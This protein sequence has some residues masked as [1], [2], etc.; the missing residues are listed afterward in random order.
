M[1]P[2][3]PREGQ[4]LCGWRHRGKGDRM[5]D[6]TEKSRATVCE[7][8]CGLLADGECNCPSRASRGD[9][10]RFSGLWAVSEGEAG[11]RRGGV[12]APSPATNARSAGIFIGVK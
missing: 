7:P 6:R 9:F 2:I 8:M 11:E 5:P 4:R 12:T 3:L 1:H 10:G